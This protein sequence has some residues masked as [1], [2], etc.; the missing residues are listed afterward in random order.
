MQFSRFSTQLHSDKNSSNMYL[1][2][3]SNI[4]WSSYARRPDESIKST[5]PSQSTENFYSSTL[6]SNETMK[7]PQINIIDMF[8][9]NNHKK[10]PGRSVPIPFYDKSNLH[11]PATANLSSPTLR[12]RE[13]FINKNIQPLGLQQIGTSMNVHKS[14]IN[15]GFLEMQNKNLPLQATTK[16][17][18]SSQ[19]SEEK[20]INEIPSPQPTPKKMLW[21]EPTWLLLHT[22]SHKVKEESFIMIR[23][24]LLSLMYSICSNL[25]CP[26]CASHARN[27]LNNINFNSIQTKTQLKLMF[28]HFHNTVNKSKNYPEFLLTE[29]DSKYSIANFKN[30]VNHFVKH[31]TN[32]TGSIK[33]I[34][35]D[36]HRKRLAQYMVQWLNK[37]CTHFDY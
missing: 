19:R 16:S 14:E 4:H 32:T 23:K 29:L 5:L 34:S 28:F 2:K 12:S 8:S 26:D 9:L 27:Y 35:D 18:S 13:H 31:Y 25:P 22:I 20:I 17:F 36:F 33:M 11:S 30:I 37:N 3:Q 15:E 24:E 21:G 7:P 1:P 10:K 6:I